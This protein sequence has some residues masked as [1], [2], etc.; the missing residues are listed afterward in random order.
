MLMQAIGALVVC[1]YDDLNVVSIATISN[2]HYGDVVKITPRGNKIYYH[3]NVQMWCNVTPDNCITP[4]CT[5]CNG[6]WKQTT[7]MGK[8]GWNNH[9]GIVQ[10]GYTTH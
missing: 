1:S 9:E 7:P 8:I 4:I 2:Q 6:V 10:K 5:S 3:I